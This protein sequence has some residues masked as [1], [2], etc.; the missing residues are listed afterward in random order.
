[1]PTSPARVAARHVKAA[2]VKTASVESILNR[3]SSEAARVR[4][5]ASAKV[6]KILADTSAAE[7]AAKDYLKRRGITVE[8]LEIEYVQSYDQAWWVLTGS[9]LIDPSMDD[10]DAEE[11]FEDL[12][13]YFR[14]DPRK[15]PY[16]SKRPRRWKIEGEGLS[17]SL[18]M[19]IL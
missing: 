16:S 7:N 5:E 11:V 8:S 6:R 10:E 13:G 9:F 12:G 15:E 19:A 4:N 1:M 3:L 17:V 18:V 2:S 14:N